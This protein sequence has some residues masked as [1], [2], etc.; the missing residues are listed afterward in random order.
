MIPRKAGSDVSY[1]TTVLA[2]AV[3]KGQ[4][5]TLSVD[6][7]PSWNRTIDRHPSWVYDY[8]AKRYTHVIINDDFYD[9]NEPV[10]IVVG[11]ASSGLATR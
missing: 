5:I 6:G 8:T 7:L 1:T 11:G 10:K 3:T 2:H 4:I 9:F